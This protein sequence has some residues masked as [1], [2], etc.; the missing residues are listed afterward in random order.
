MDV[1]PGKDPGEIHWLAGVRTFD[2]S[3]PFHE[4]QKRRLWMLLNK[5]FCDELE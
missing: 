3:L 2:G 1:T 4:V 5:N